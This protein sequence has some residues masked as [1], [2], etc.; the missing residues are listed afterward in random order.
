MHAAL[1][2]STSQL[3]QT[4]LG[5]FLRATMEPPPRSEY[6][7]DDLD[8]HV[9]LKYR[10]IASNVAHIRNAQIICLAETHCQEDQLLKPGP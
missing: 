1:P 6:R 5:G 7:T 9:R 3:L 4:S 2:L 10:V 8:L